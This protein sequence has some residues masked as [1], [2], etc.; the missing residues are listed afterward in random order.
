[1]LLSRV[2]LLLLGVAHGFQIRPAAGGTA[3]LRRGASRAAAPRGAADG[4][5]KAR[6]NVGAALVSV[7]AA[8]APLCAS[9]AGP[10]WVEPL[11]T[12]LGP[13]LFGI[14]F[15]MLGR[16]LLSWYP[17]ININKLPFNLIAWPTEPILRATRSVVPPAFGVDISPIVWIAVASLSSELL[18][19]Q[20]GVLILMQK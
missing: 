13:A 19:G 9:A 16:V 8:T 3:A 12:F 10:E 4:D 14:Q 7:A 18:L 15:V 2:V 17:E 20:Q 5:V 1:M 11:A 6:R